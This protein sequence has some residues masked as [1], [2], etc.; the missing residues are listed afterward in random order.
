[1][2]TLSAAQADDVRQ[3][4]RAAERRCSL[5]FALFLGSP[6]GGRAPLRRAAARRARR[7]G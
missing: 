3:A 6:V 4:L 1:M 7:G 2:R 5:R